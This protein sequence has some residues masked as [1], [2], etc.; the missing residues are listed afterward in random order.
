GALA[1]GA[2]ISY[3][4]SDVVSLSGEVFYA[5]RGATTDNAILGG[6]E[7]GLDGDIAITYVDLPLMLGFRLP[8][9]SPVVP[10]LLLGGGYGTNVETLITLRNETGVLESSSDDSIAKSDLFG[11]VGAA[12]DLDVGGQRIVFETRATFGFKNVRPERADVP[13]RNTALIFT[14][15]LDF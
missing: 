8:I 10:R 7:T 13:L 1:G 15:G 4:F 9:E 2:S 12:V 5:K 6:T 11:I 14:V 3:W